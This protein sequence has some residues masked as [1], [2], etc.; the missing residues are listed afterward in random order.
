MDGLA[1]LWVT[2]LTIGMALGM[3]AFSLGIGLGAR[4]LRWR[5]VGRLTILVAVMHVILPLVGIWLGDLLYLRF[6]GM[7]Q[8]VAAIILMFL[9]AKM[10]LEAW[11]RD[12]ANAPIPISANLLA[13]GVLAFSVS[14]DSLSVG[15]TLGT[16]RIHPFIPSLLLSHLVGSV[17]GCIFC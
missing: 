10:A 14:V 12:D 15:F 4:G 8:K 16:F 6:G 13:L 2:L 3:D 9:G 17:R 1:G 5:D 7:I 11:R